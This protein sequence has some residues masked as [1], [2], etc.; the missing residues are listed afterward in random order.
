M[1]LANVSEAYK[2]VIKFYKQVGE[3]AWL[4]LPAWDHNASV[5]GS[6]LPHMYLLPG[7]LSED[8]YQLQQRRSW[9]WN[10]RSTLI[11]KDTVL[12][13]KEKKGCLKHNLVAL[14]W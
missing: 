7:V 9:N 13:Q 4:I 5:Q 6:I 8:T 11:C 14:I 2:K 1:F 12:Q 3:K 10:E